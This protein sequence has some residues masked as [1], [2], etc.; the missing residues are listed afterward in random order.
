MAVS[1]PSGAVAVI[2]AGATGKSGAALRLCMASPP[3]RFLADDTFFVNRDGVCLGSVGDVVV[4]QRNV[5]HP[6]VQ[7]RRRAVAGRTDLLAWE[8]HARIGSRGLRRHIPPDTLLEPDS[9]VTNVP[10]RRIV[11]IRRAQV[12]APISR[13]ADQ[14][15]AE[16]VIMKL[17]KAE[18]R[19]LWSPRDVRS[20]PELGEGWARD[21]VSGVMSA[22]DIELV[23]ALLPAPAS[24]AAAESFIMQ[25][26]GKPR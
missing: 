17:L 3:W 20:D 19:H 10:L 8:L 16:L 25:V 24:E 23:E 18:T 11:V 21:V 7:G 22:N 13:C 5:S 6:D 9:R 2:G 26:V 1:G 4:A 15:A 12:A 14:N